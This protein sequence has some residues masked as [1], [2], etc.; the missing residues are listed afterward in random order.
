MNNSDIFKFCSLTVGEVIVS[1]QLLKFSHPSSFNDPFD[2]DINLLR[3][4]FSDCSEEI[5]NEFEVLR[6]GAINKFGEDVQPLFDE[7]PINR[8]EEFYK[9]SQLDKIARSSVCC[10]SKEYENT[11]LWAHYA[12]NHKGICLIF[13]LLENRPFK[14]YDPERFAQGPIDYDNY[15]PVNYLKSK[16]DGISR[17][18][19][20]KSPDWR[21]EKE[22]RFQILEE[23]GYLKFNKT[24]LKGIIFGLRVTDY[25]INRFISVCRRFDYDSLGFYR[26]KKAKLGMQLISI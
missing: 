17:L 16:F 9:K 3:F 25:E 24:F 10:F 23:S 5:K 22:Y 15:L 21:Y 12:D 7:I 6:T 11:V 4:D 13:D 19:F 18:F 20:A 8:F 14:D 2:C 1:S 26:F